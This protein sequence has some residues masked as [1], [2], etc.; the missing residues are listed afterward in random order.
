[1]TI[2]H[3]SVEMYKFLAMQEA[4][5]LST[6]VNEINVMVLDGDTD[7]ES[8]LFLIDQATAHMSRLRSW[9]INYGERMEH[10]G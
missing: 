9:L 8:A 1:M 7:V 10:D 5:N 2:G 3:K 6:Q 4:K